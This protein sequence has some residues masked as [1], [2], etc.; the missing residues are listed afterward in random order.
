MHNPHASIF[1]VRA[2]LGLV[3]GLGLVGVSLCRGSSYFYYFAYLDFYGQGILYIRSACRQSATGTCQSLTGL[4]PGGFSP[5]AWIF[6]GDTSRRQPPALPPSRVFAWRLRCNPGFCS[7]SPCGFFL[8]S[9]NA[10]RGFLGAPLRSGF[11]SPLPDGGLERNRACAS[12]LPW[13]PLGFG[14]RR[15]AGI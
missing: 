12:N 10:C 8:R 3:T 5:C 1:R 2:F 9:S 14:E 15:F 7:C 11:F 13:A 4:T 6:N